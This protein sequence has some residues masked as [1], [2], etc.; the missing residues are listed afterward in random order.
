MRLTNEWHNGINDLGCGGNRDIP[1]T[2]FPIDR[3]TVTP[4]SMGTFQGWLGV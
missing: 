1:E 3:A 2:D 4:Y